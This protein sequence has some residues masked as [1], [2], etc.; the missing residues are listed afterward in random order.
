MRDDP[1]PDVSSRAPFLITSCLGGI[2]ALVAGTWFVTHS[3]PGLTF[4]DSGEFGLAAASAGVPHAPGAPTWTSLATFFTRLITAADPVRATNIL[5]GLLAALSLGL[6][7]MLVRTWLRITHPDLPTWTNLAG[8]AAAA[9]VLAGSPAFLQQGLITEQYTLLTTLL[10]AVLLTATFLVP[11]A[12]RPRPGARWP[13]IV[14]VVAMGAGLSLVTVEL[15]SAWLVFVLPGTAA[16]VLLGRL[17]TRG[18]PVAADVW[19]AAW[20]G[21]LW[22]RACGNHLSQLV[23]GTVVVWALIEAGGR[24]PRVV[25][26]LAV[27]AAAGFLLGLSVFVW[28]MLRS[29][30][31]P[32]L[33]W[34]NVETWERLWWAVTRLDWSSRPLGEAPPGFLAAWLGSFGIVHQVGWPGTAL[35]AVGL[36][37]VLRRGRRWASWLSLA[38]LPYLIGIY[39]AH[40]RQQGIGLDYI[41]NYGISDWHLPLH[42]ALAALAGWGTCL[43]LAVGTRRARRRWLTWSVTCALL[44]VLFLRGVE[45]RRQASRRHD[46][47][48]RRFVEALFAG[49]PRRALVA[50]AESEHAFM[51]AYS[52]Y[53]ARKRPDT[54]IAYARPGFGPFFANGSQADRWSAQRQDRFLATL[55]AAKNVN[56]VRAPELSPVDRTT[57]PLIVDFP[58]ENPAAAT[59]LLPRGLLYEVMGEPVP[60]AAVR[61]AERRWR[62]G[63]ARALPTPDTRA[64]RPVRYAWYRVHL[65]RSEYFN[66]L[67]LWP[68]AVA[69]ATEAVAWLPDQGAGQ[70]ALG[71]ALMNGGQPAHAARALRSAVELDPDLAGPRTMLAGIALDNGDHEEAR[72]LLTEELERFPDDDDAL[73]LRRYMQQGSNR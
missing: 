69:A 61:E 43:L 67:G 34:G 7:A 70:Y 57:R 29:R 68:E 5:S 14:A 65:H 71:F 6:L 30:T 25:G 22:G 11:A 18:A 52:R 20:L 38:V 40:A 9:L 28:M 58:R 21:F 10:L 13:G 42:L 33:D 35:A 47:T 36:V 64:R 56:P 15:P 60:P 37:A 23:L 4:H 59:H 72:R 73:T 32:V 39:L 55:A 49:T 62:S 46:D 44:V 1:V 26:R 51:M 50:V 8:A 12:D 66:L 19:T 3:A 54:W 41:T 2:V 63:T 45:P 17:L 16:I 31:D 53:A 24:K 48:G 27:M